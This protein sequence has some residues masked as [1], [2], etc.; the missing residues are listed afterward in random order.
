MG[1]FLSGRLLLDMSV[2]LSVLTGLVAP[3]SHS[4]QRIDGQIGAVAAPVVLTS[5]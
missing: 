4:A 2:C 5:K 3:S 1:D